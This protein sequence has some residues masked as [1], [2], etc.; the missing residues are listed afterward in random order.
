MYLLFICRG[1]QWFCCGHYPLQGVGLWKRDF[2]GPWN[3]NERSECHLRPQKGRDFIR[4]LSQLCPG[5]RPQTYIFPCLMKWPKL[6][7]WGKYYNIEKG[8]NNGKSEQQSTMTI[9]TQQPGTNN[10]PP[11]VTSQLNSQQSTTNIGPLTNNCDGQIH[12]TTKTITVNNQQK[13][14]TRLEARTPFA[15]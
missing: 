3:G 15:R 9:N 6:V 1:T 2:F 10:N 7:R 5:I 4:L 13:E 11:T 14:K 8:T 12:S